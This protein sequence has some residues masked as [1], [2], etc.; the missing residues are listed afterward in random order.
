MMQNIF[1]KTKP[2]ISPTRKYKKEMQLLEL[3]PKSR[4]IATIEYKHVAHSRFELLVDWLLS[5]FFYLKVTQTSRVR[6]CKI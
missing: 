4:K 2:K 1:S 6:F 5:K 3:Q